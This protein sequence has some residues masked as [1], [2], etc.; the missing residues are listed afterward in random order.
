MKNREY[1]KRIYSP[2]L[3]ME[4]LA[5]LARNFPGIIAAMRN[6]QLGRS[7]MEKIMTVV[8]TINGCIYC[9]WFHA[10]QAASSGISQ[11]E[12]QDLFELQFQKKASEFELPALQYA[13]HYTETNRKP[14][15]E[16][17]QRLVEFYGEKNAHHIELFIRM[18]YFGNLQGN[19]FD[20]FPAR[21][22]GEK[23]PGGNPLFEFFFYIIN[24]PLMLPLFPF[25]YRFRKNTN[26][27]AEKPTT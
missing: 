9:S 25:V 16:M 12:I 23:I 5:F 18:I 4:D 7:F 19:T 22:R 15:P 11:E 8:T 1:K 26:P 20:A 14:V 27:G 3:F 10:N 21:L 13:Q 6:K 24:F 17:K 2:E